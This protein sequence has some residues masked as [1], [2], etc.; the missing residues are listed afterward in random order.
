MPRHPHVLNARLVGIDRRK[1][2]EKSSD[3][4]NSLCDSEEF[5]NRANPRKMPR[6]SL[7]R[8]ASGLGHRSSEFAGLR[9]FQG[10]RLVLGERVPFLL[11]DIGEGISEVEVLKW[12]RSEGEPVNPFDK[13]LD[14]ESDKAT[15]EITSRYRGILR[16]L[17]YRPGEMAPV[18][19]PLVRLGLLPSMT[20]LH[21][22]FR[23]TYIFPVL[24]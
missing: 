4:C 16:D 1:E 11:A 9:Y 15:V 24:R 20:H 14:V 19:R 13:L 7:L 6:S 18:G 3:K 12:H 8:L 23:I 5:L 17:Q 10:A 2:Q 22:T 21:W